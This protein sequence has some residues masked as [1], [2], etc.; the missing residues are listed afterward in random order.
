MAAGDPRD[1]RRD[2]RHHRADCRGLLA[3]HPLQPPVAVPATLPTA[4]I[5]MLFKLSG[6]L[7]QKG[8]IPELVHRPSEAVELYLYYFVLMYL[9]IFT[10]RIAELE[11]KENADRIIRSSLTAPHTSAPTLA[12]L[13]TRRLKWT[14]VAANNVGSGRSQSPAYVS[15]FGWIE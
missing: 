8:Y 15:V 12:C 13:L 14:R 3:A 6:I 1:W 9:L 4:V 5:A 7:T 2:R 11:T 10:R